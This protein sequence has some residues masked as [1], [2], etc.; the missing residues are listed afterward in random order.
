[1]F[2]TA[3]LQPGAF[4]EHLKSLGPERGKLLTDSLTKALQTPDE[5]ALALMNAGALSIKKDA[6]T[7]GLTTTTG[8]VPYSL[9]GPAWFLAPKVTPLRNMIPRRPIGGTGHHWKRITGIDTSGSYGFVSEET[10]ATAQSIAGR[11]G[12]INFVEEDDSTTFATLGADDFLTLQAQ[13]GGNTTINSGMDFQPE[14]VSRLALLQAVQ[15]R[16]EK[17]IIGANKTGLGSPA[18]VADAAVQ[19]PATTGTLTPSQAYKVRVS[20]LSYLGVSLGSTG[21]ASADAGGETSAAASFTTTC[22]ASG[23]GS[24]ARAITWT[25][26][27]KA[28]AYNFYADITTPKYV[29]TVYANNYT[30]TAL[31]SSTNVPNTSDQTADSGAYDGLLSLLPSRVGYFKNLGGAALTFVG[32]KCVE[33]DTAFYQHFIDKKLGVDNLW[34]AP[35]IKKVLNEGCTGASSPSQTIFLQAN[36]PNNTQLRGGLG[37]EYLWNDYAQ[38]W[39]KLNVH[40]LMPD[41]VVFGTCSD[42]GQFYPNSRTP[43]P[44]EMLLGFDYISIDF[45]QVSTRRE[46]GTYVFGAPAIKAG[47]PMI[48]VKGIG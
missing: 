33:L 45:A 38:R 23:A 8:L 19:P 5:N 44:I 31:G 20:A 34:M 17:A 43:N 24:D 13:Y 41:G 16:E 47:F 30:L 11:A 14:A 37:M 6:T 46:F 18:S 15:I 40:P 2:G 32:G 1:M 27:P 22:A 9:E 25:D 35:R 42:L 29:A 28:V 21:H 26:L 4:F 36:D 48:E 10:S 39:V 12:F 7:T 3:P